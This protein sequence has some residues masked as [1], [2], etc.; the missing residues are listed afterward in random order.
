MSKVEELKAKFDK[1]VEQREAARQ[2]IDPDVDNSA[3]EYHRLEQEVNDA[4]RALMDARYDAGQGT[5]D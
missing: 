3:D 2:R 1:L 5:L 4:Y